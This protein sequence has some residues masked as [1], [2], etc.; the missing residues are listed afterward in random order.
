MFL[1]ARKRI[2]NNLEFHKQDQK[3]IKEY[4]EKGHAT[5]IKNENNTNNVIGY[6][7]HDGVVNINKP[8]KV[9]V[10]FDAGA[11]YHSTSLNKSIL[12][13]PGLL[14]NLV[15]VLTRFRMERYPAMD[16]IEQM[17]HQIVSANFGRK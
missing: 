9:K 11:T 7:H 12:K 3:T 5:E 10:V 1:I 13:G 15:G 17:I 14:Y 2:K 16:D 4:I 8:G 6:L